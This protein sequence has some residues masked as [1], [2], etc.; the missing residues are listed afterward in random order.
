MQPNSIRSEIDVQLIA[1]RIMFVSLLLVL[2]VLLVYRS[3]LP[4]EANTVTFPAA[5]S[6]VSIPPLR[7][8]P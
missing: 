8:L 4:L 6:S 2:V 3:N 1:L 7:S 5:L